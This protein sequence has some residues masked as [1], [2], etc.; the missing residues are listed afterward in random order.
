M[1][2]PGYRPSDVA[3]H[4]EC[5]RHDGELLSLAAGQAGLGAPVPACPGWAVRDL[6]KHTGYVHRWA[7]GYVAEQSTDMVETPGEDEV[8]THGPADDVLLD[9]FRDGHASLVRALAAADPDLKC[10]TFMAAPSPLAFWARQAGSRAGARVGV[11]AGVRVGVWVRV[12]AGVWAGS[13]V[14]V[15]AGARPAGRGRRR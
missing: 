7:T 3:Y 6:L 13:R 10:W 15:R 14:G 8:L 1:Q 5:L 4:I 12:W 2:M 9:W 11:W